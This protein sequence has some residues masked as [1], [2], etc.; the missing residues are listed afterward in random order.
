MDCKLCGKCCSYICLQLDEPED[1]G[2]IENIK[3]YLVHEKV[4]VFI[5]DHDDWYLQVFT[6]CKYLNDENKCDFYIQGKEKKRPKICKIHEADSCENS[7]LESEEKFAFENYDDFLAFL[8]EYDPFS[9][10]KKK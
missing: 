8:K 4:R 5:D 3:W 7:D 10:E 2:D 1:K 6:R 9:L